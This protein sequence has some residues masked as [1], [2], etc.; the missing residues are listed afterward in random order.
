MTNKYIWNNLET[1]N[2]FYS[3][4]QNVCKFRKKH[5]L[6]KY[7]QCDLQETMINSNIYKLNNDCLIL[8]FLHLPIVDRIRIERGIYNLIIYNKQ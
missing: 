3:T 7:N 4:L 1:S 2:Q 8:I 6:E 5:L